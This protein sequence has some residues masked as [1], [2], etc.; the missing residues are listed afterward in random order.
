MP[1]PTLHTAALAT[2][3]AAINTALRYDPGTRG[4][5]GR[6]QG[7]ILEI[8]SSA[9]RLRC[10]IAPGPEGLRLLGHCE[11]TVTTRL[12]GSLPAL[13]SL[14]AGDAGSLAGSGVEIEGST[15]LPADL[16]RILKQLDIDWEEPLSRLLGDVAGHQAGNLIRTSLRWLGGRRS[17][18]Q[19]LLVEYLTEELRSLP[20]QVEVD[21]FCNDVDAIRL[22][23]DR[24]G[25]KV[26]ELKQRVERLQPP[27][28][29]PPA[30]EH[31]DT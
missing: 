28:P 26:A 31:R 27:A 11:E 2:L 15:A 19:R 3:E 18:A 4:A 17:T 10:F 21:G 13:L 6:L 22:S 20:G 24:L 9:P 7:Q 29:P 30:L 25:A 8:E 23:A 12:H 1:D 5:L 14:A 16:Q